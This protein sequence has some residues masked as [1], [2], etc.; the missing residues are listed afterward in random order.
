MVNTR[1]SATDGNPDVGNTLAQQNDTLAAIAARLDI[2]DELRDKVAALEVHNR[3]PTTKKKIYADNSEEESES[4]SRRHFQPLYAK[5]EFP[6]FS[7]GDPRGWILKAEKYFRYYETPDEEKV[8][9]ASMYLEGDALDMFSWALS[10]LYWEELVKILQEQYGPPEYQNPDEYLAAVQQVETVQE[11]RV[12]WAR[13]V[14]RVKNWPDH[15]LLGIFL[16][17]LKEELRSEVRIHKPQSVYRA[18]SLALEMEKKLQGTQST[19]PCSTASSARATYSTNSG[20]NQSVPD[21]SAKTLT[22]HNP[23]SQNPG[24]SQ[25]VIPF[26]SNSWDTTRQERRNKGLCFRWGDPFRPGHRFTTS[27]FSLMEVDVEGNPIPETFEPAPKMEEIIEE[28]EISFNA[29]LGTSSA[30]TM[31]LQGSIQNRNVLCLVDSGSTHNFISERLVN[32]LNLVITSIP[33]LGV[34]IGDGSLVRCG[35]ICKAVKLQLPGLSITQDFYPFSLSG[36]DLVLGIKWLASLN[37]IQANWNEMFL[38]FWVDGKR[39][40]NGSALNGSDCLFQPLNG[41]DV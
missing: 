29:I 25:S 17:G 14:A 11:Y 22:S 21:S 4:H 40:L 32:E 27:T 34:Q 5:I 6:K 13:R 38:I 39:C 16:N 30:A 37:T 41:S 24:S 33:V 36:S 10:V 2:L 35:K 19:R 15:C 18:T 26:R 1:S 3:N 12:E 31:K 7:G 8:D 9:I 28:A 23:T 20:R